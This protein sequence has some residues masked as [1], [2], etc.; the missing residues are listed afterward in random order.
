MAL[1]QLFVKNKPTF[2][3]GGLS[4][5]A[6]PPIEFDASIRE[7]HITQFTITQTPIEGGALVADHVL[8]QPERLTMEVVA[9]AHTDTLIPNLIRTRPKRIYKQLQ[10]IARLRLPFDVVTTLAI[11]T[12]MIIE[13]IRVPRT[14]TETFALIISVS[15]RKLEVATV[16]VAEAMSEAMEEIARGKEDLGAVAAAAQ[17]AAPV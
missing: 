4:V 2:W 10:Q 1:V 9:T 6:P 7:E 13:A 8:E 5:Q 12:N 16:D 15:L 11:Y 14:K 17:A 3:P